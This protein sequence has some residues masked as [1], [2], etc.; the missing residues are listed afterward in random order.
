MRRDGRRFTVFQRFD[1]N[2]LGERFP[3]CRAN[4]VD[5]HLRVLVG[6]LLVVVLIEELERQITAEPV[7]AQR[8]EDRVERRDAVAGIDPLGVGDPGRVVG[9]ADS[10]SHGTYAVT[11][12]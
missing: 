1:H 10:R 2:A 6:R 12:R 3:D 11:R 8:T 5:P 9:P 4:L 7:V